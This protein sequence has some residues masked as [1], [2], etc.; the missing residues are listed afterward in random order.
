MIKYI[1]FTFRNTDK[2]WTKL[3]KYMV[4]FVSDINTSIYEKPLEICQQLLVFSI[5][6][7]FYLNCRYQSSDNF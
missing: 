3:I 1:L 2:N 7:F 6:I 5:N 4:E